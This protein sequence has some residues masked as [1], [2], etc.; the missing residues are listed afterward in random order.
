M[1]EVIKCN[2]KYRMIELNLRYQKGLT[3]NDLYPKL[4]YYCACGCGRKLLGKRIKWATDECRYNSFIN[5]AIIKGNNKI[6]RE[7]LFKRDE[8]FCHICGQYDDHW[9]ADHI[10]SVIKNGGACDLTNF[11]TH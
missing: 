9:Q 4:D 10:T 3:L 6:I 2:F 5:F 11:Q 8:G 7:E 1:E